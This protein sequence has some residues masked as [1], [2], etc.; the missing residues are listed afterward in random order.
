LIQHGLFCDFFDFFLG[1]LKGLIY[2]SF[3][4]FRPRLLFRG[5][6]MTDRKRAGRAPT[7]SLRVIA[8]YVSCWLF[9]GCRIIEMDIR[10]RERDG[11]GVFDPLPFA[12]QA[13]AGHYL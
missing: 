13:D 10:L 4:P 7:G 3:P 6:R 9:F 12:R 5:L 8:W 2:F 11:D 1:R